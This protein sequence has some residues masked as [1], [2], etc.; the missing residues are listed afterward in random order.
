MTDLLNKQ[1][2]IGI[3]YL[4]ILQVQLHSFFSDNTSNINKGYTYSLHQISTQ[5]TYMESQHSQHNPHSDTLGAIMLVAS[6]MSQ[7]HASVSLGWNCQ[8]NSACCH[9]KIE[10]ADQTCYLTMSQCTDTWPT[11]PSIDLYN[12]RHLAFWPTE[13]QFY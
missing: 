12:T 11:S 10:A 6:L 1:R 7:L 9:T 4:D 5:H 3:L 13:Y 2:L 8:D